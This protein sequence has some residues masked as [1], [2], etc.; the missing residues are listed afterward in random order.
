MLSYRLDKTN[1]MCKV[2]HMRLFSYLSL[3]SILLCAHCLDIAV[4]ADNNQNAF[5]YDKGINVVKKYVHSY[6]Q[7]KVGN[8]KIYIAYP[9]KYKQ[10]ED[11]NS[12]DDDENLDVE[13]TI[14]QKQMNV[15]DPYIFLTGAYYCAH[16]HYTDLATALYK[17][18][19]QLE[20]GNLDALSS[21]AA[22]HQQNSEYA[23]CIAIYAKMLQLNPRDKVTLN[24]L[25]ATLMLIDMDKAQKDLEYL[26]EIKEDL[27]IAHSY[28]GLILAKKNNYKQ[29]IH[30]IAEAFKI[31]P[32]TWIYIYNLAVMYDK[33]KKYKEALLVYQY[34]LSLPLG[35]D[36]DPMRKPVQKRVSEILDIL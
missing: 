12:D 8:N 36:F 13:L 5:I 10:L 20:P 30:H 11:Y 26:L 17:K 3:F 31:S 21:L 32:K 6:N 16:N 18:V 19:L 7:S 29:A 15:Q 4:S 28:L 23:A 35:D 9:L 25:F 33:I 1:T 14:L 2:V 22:L 24:N 34:L 27:D